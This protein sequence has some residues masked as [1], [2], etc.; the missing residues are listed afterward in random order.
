[1]LTIAAI[2]LL[3]IILCAFTGNIF[4]VRVNTPTSQLEHALM[5]SVGVNRPPQRAGSLD[6]ILVL[7]SPINDIIIQAWDLDRVL[8]FIELDI[9]I[10]L[11][12]CPSCAGS[13]SGTTTLVIGKQ[14]IKSCIQF[15]CREVK[16]S[17]V[18]R[19][20]GGIFVYDLKHTC[21]VCSPPAIPAPKSPSELPPP[22]HPAE[23]IPPPVSD[24]KEATPALKLPPRTI[25]RVN[26]ESS[27]PAI[28]QP[29]LNY[30]PHWTFDQSRTVHFEGPYQIS[31]RIIITDS[32]DVKYEPT[33]LGNLGTKPMPFDFGRNIPL[34]PR[35]SAR[36]VEVQTQV[37][38]QQQPDSSHDR[39]PSPG[40]VTVTSTESDEY[41]DIRSM[42]QPISTPPVTCVPPTPKPRK[43]FRYPRV[44]LRGDDQAGLVDHEET[45]PPSI[46]PKKSGPKPIPR[47]RSK[48]TRD[49]GMQIDVGVTLT[50]SVIA[51]SRP[52][53]SSITSFS[54]IVELVQT[55]L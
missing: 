48:T 21:G 45:K 4:H 6:Q 31:S 12:L 8:R 25:P 29:Y 30:F 53:S 37:Q 47:R 54:S 49:S 26:Y 41:V 50:S 13:Q 18:P 22:Y 40:A 43:Y 36:K 23:V 11:V 2:M 16:I 19:N 5:Y 7:S 14:S 39:L 3:T 15:L 20:D 52:R 42:R 27:I 35:H 32:G 51:E 10:R 46:P 24:Q 55:P 34:P 38:C 9:G 33:V 17:E 28:A 44:E 1:M